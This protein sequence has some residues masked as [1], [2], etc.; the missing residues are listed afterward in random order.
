MLEVGRDACM[1]LVGKLKHRLRFPCVRYQR[2]ESFPMCASLSS[3][4]VLLLHFRHS[5]HLDQ[6]QP[7]ASSSR[8]RYIPN[9]RFSPLN[10]PTSPSIIPVTSLIPLSSSLRLSTQRLSISHI[11]VFGIS[12]PVAGGIWRAFG[13]RC[14]FSL[15]SVPREIAARL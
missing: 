2:T 4:F 3:P 10:L 11:I 1:L 14:K 7:T 15:C 8:T 13:L 5:C 12:I 6:I 9:P